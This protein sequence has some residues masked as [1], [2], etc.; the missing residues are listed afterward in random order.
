MLGQG[1]VVRYLAGQ[2]ASGQYM[3]W[4]S[5]LGRA[6]THWV[7][8]R[9]SARDVVWLGR[10]GQFLHGGVRRVG[11]EQAMARQASPRTECPGMDT[12]G[13]SGFGT[14][15][16]VGHGRKRQVGAR[17]GEAGTV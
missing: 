2:F 4:Q 13:R 6:W 16:A 1:A 11:A 17:R 3:A 7:A 8:H 10:R 9:K 14:A 15:G 12:H 5:R